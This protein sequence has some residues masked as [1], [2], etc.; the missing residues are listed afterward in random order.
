ML[1]DSPA[2]QSDLSVSNEGTSL[3]RMFPADP[4]APQGAGEFMLNWTFVYKFYEGLIEHRRD[5]PGDVRGPRLRAL[6]GDGRG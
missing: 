5:R 2:A 1:A 6:P 4:E 3:G